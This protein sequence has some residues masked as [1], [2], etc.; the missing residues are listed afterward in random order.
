MDILDHTLGVF[1]LGGIE[2]EI[3]PL[4]QRDWLAENRASF[5][6]LHIGRIWIHGSHV[7]HAAPVGSLPLLVEAAQAFGSGTHP[8]TEGCLWAIQMIAA[9][10]R[11]IP[12]RILDMGC[13][14]AILAMA[15]QK[16]WP[17]SR[18]MAVDNDPVAVRVASANARL[19]RIAP[20]Q[21][22][23]VFSTGFAG[24]A[25][26]LGGRYNVILA[27]I[28]AGPLRRMASDLALHLSPNGWLILSGILNEQ[29]V[30]VERAYAAKGLRCWD[31]LRIG[32]W[33]TIIMR[34]AVVGAIPRLWHGRRPSAMITQK[35]E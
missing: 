14:S 13:G 6:P 3:G 22:R 16:I 24:R 31:M 27:N 20:Q 17:S 21:M 5:P 25:V 29:A 9:K 8:T 28:L 15:A 18:L 32:D 35:D 26:R 30:G 23:C 12:R 11:P 34:P 7:G 10:S 2:L 4:R 19:N 33:T 1:G